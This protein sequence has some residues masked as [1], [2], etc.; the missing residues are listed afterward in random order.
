MA[1]GTTTATTATR[2]HLDIRTRPDTTALPIRGTIVM[3]TPHAS[4]PEAVT[5]SAIAP[6]RALI[7]T[8]IRNTGAHTRA[9]SANSPTNASMT[10][11]AK[12]C[13]TGSPSFLFSAW[14]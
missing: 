4:G 6:I 12:D 1:V 3:D 7:A 11:R 10:W 13:L 14:R 8:A 9:G 5:V 2:T